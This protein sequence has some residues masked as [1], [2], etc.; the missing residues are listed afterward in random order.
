MG[1]S[2]GFRNCRFFGRS[3]GSLFRR[4]DST[5]LLEGQTADLSGK[6][7]GCV[8]WHAHRRDGVCVRGGLHRTLKQ[9]VKIK[10]EKSFGG[11]NERRCN[12]NSGT[13]LDSRVPLRMD[14]NGS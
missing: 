2:P 7:W 5:L 3:S 12:Q 10:L 13:L 8:L 6:Q 11:W 9:M 1:S 4:V 14:P